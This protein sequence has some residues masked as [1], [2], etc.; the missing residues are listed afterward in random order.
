MT[1]IGSSSDA[2]SAMWVVSLSLALW[3][4][5]NSFRYSEGILFSTMR[6]TKSGRLYLGT[7]RWSSGLSP[8]TPSIKQT[9]KLRKLRSKLVMR[10][11]LTRRHSE[12][13]SNRKRQL[14][15]ASLRQPLCCATIN[16]IIG[17]GPSTRAR[18]G[19]GSSS[20]ETVNGSKIGW[21]GT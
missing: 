14:K 1:P 2:R 10:W 21:N 17:C 12:L 7:R 16:T 5:S 3:P 15:S 11:R 8:T 19:S 4:S 20:G 18:V 13:S 9:M 6:T